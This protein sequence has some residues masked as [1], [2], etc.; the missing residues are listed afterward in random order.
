MWISCI[1]L[2]V[3]RTLCWFSLDLSKIS[4]IDVG[5]I[6]VIDLQ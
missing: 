5:A 3:T 6:V 2:K 1:L 4:V